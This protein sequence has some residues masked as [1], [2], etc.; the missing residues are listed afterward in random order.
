MHRVALLSHFFAC[1]MLKSCFSSSS[2]LHAP[3][4]IASDDSQM[5]RRCHT[6]GILNERALMQHITV[7][8]D[9][10]QPHSSSESSSSLSSSSSSSACLVGVAFLVF[11]FFFLFFDLALLGFARGNSR[12]LRISSSVIFLSVFNLS[13]SGFGG[14]AN[15]WRPFLVMATRSQYCFSTRYMLHLDLPMVVKSLLTGSLSVDPMT[16]YCRTTPPRTHSTMPILPARSSS[17]C[18]RLNGNVPNFF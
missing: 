5:T 3:E 16:S 13:R 6:H 1:L 7:M 14:A 11:F 18:R 8:A 12:I 9:G 10:G 2:S 17:S 15:R 4:S